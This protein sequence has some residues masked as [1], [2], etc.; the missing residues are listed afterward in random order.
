MNRPT[1]QV[2]SPP[3]THTMPTNGVIRPSI[4]VHPPPPTQTMPRNYF[5]ATEQSSQAQHRISPTQSPAWRTSGEAERL[6][7]YHSP[8]SSSAPSPIPSPIAS[9]TSQAVISASDQRPAGKMRETVRSVMRNQ[10][11]EA[12][13]AQ[14]LWYFLGLSVAVNAGCLLWRANSNGTPHLTTLESHHVM[15]TDGDGVPDHRDLCPRSAKWFTSGRATDF[16][17]DGCADDTE[18]RDKDNDGILDLHD[19]C[20]L[21][22]QKYTFVSNAARDFDS[23][24]CAD[25]VEDMDDD[26]DLI[27][28]SIDGC[29][30]TASGEL[31]DSEGCSGLQ[32]EVRAQMSTQ[33]QSSPATQKAQETKSSKLEEWINL[34][35]GCGLQIILGGFLSHGAEKAEACYT[36]VKARIP[37]D[38]AEEI[39]RMS[40]SSV[41]RL[42]SSD[43]AK[44]VRRFSSDVAAQTE[45]WIPVLKKHGIRILCYLAV[46]FYLRQHR[47]ALAMESTSSWFAVGVRAIVGSCPK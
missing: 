41:K 33:P 45:S 12:S 11:S 8:V 14:F 6:A 26:N 37:E 23:D 40:S 39:R 25:G 22:P 29:P 31:S 43:P 1:V 17:S 36:S 5:H 34:I 24:G 30:L 35:I 15:D 32:R 42:S 4:E 27:P 19:K 9:P 18:D 38:P 44:S 16:D 3:P 2:I 21:T 10:K 13:R 20:P 28:N 46:F 47:C 7:S